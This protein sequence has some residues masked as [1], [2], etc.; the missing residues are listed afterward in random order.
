VLASAG[1]VP[2]MAVMLRTPIVHKLLE[3][4]RSEGGTK[5]Q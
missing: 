5:V 3:E 2:A 4:N 1:V